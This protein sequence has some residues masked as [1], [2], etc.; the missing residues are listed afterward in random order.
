VAFGKLSARRTGTCRIIHPK[1][2]NTGFNN[3]SWFDRAGDFRSDA[4]HVVERFTPMD[5]TRLNYEATIEDPKVFTQ[6]W[7]I[8]L[9][10]YR[11]VEKAEELLYG[12]LRKK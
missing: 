6:P 3:L 9:P 10:L 7:R 5:A 12:D 8:S 4:L 1:V 2:D 11:R